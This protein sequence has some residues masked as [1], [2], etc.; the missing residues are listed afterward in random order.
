MT[1]CRILACRGSALQTKIEKLIVTL[2]QWSHLTKTAKS[3]YFLPGPSEEANRW[4]SA[5]I[6]NE[7]QS[8]F[9][10]IFTGIG[11]IEGTF[12]L[13]VK[14]DSKVCQALPRKVADAL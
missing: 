14:A 3:T 8:K 2:I 1:R 5:M 7:L 6:P 12:A 11:C 4:A 9:E 10:D 13:Q